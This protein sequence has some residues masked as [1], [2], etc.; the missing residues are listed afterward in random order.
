MGILGFKVHL[1]CSLS[2]YERGVYRPC[3]GPHRCQIEQCNSSSLSSS[4]WSWLNWLCPNNGNME[5]IFSNASRSTCEPVFYQKALGCHHF[6]NTTIFDIGDLT[7]PGCLADRCL[8]SDP[9][10][11]LSLLAAGLYVHQVVRASTELT[12]LDRVSVC[13]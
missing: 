3:P 2:D 9:A 8:V 10:S 1:H 13:N 7:V 4:A 11:T 5:R 6:F 12:N